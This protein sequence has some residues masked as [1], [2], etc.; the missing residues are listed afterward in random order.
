[1]AQGKIYVRWAPAIYNSRDK[2]LFWVIGDIWSDPINHPTK[3]VVGTPNDI[4][5]CDILFELVEDLL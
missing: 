3:V 4:P 1:M 2:H 5:V